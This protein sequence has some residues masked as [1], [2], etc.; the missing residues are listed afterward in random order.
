LGH[1]GRTVEGN[2]RIRH[3]A[4]RIVHNALLSSLNSIKSCG[5]PGRTIGEDSTR[6]GAENDSAWIQPIES[7]GVTSIPA[8]EKEKCTPSATRAVADDQAKED[9]VFRSVVHVD[10]RLHLSHVGE[11]GW[12][13]NGKESIPFLLSVSRAIQV[14]V[15]FALRDL[16]KNNPFPAMREYVEEMLKKIQ[17]GR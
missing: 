4:T 17:A 8:L 14:F 11:V 7:N 12:K 16:A 9:A 10:Q 1:A 2:A 6:A 3:L 5:S 13:T 15:R